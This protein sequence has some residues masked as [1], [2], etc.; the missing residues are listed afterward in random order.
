MF[1]CYRHIE[2]VCGLI[3]NFSFEI[4]FLELLTM[5]REV[6]LYVRVEVDCCSDAKCIHLYLVESLQ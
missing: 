4:S 6:N 2:T 5:F 1:I 3:I